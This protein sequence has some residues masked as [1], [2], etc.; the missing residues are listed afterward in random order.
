MSLFL[1]FL[2]VCLFVSVFLTFLRRIDHM[3]SFQKFT[4]SLNMNSN[5]K[6][7]KKFTTEMFTCVFI[8]TSYLARCSLSVTSSTGSLKV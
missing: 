2:F 8:K 7:N 1:G 5:H 4:I 6:L 3:V